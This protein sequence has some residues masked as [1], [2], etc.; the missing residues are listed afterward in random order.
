MSRPVEILT[1]P[2]KGLLYDGR[3]PDGLVEYHPMTAKEEKYLAGGFKDGNAIIDAII[4]SCVP[5]LTVPVDDLLI[6]DKFFMMLVI[7]ASSYGSSYGMEIKCPNCDKK[8]RHEIDL[9]FSEGSDEDAAFSIKVLDDGAKEPF[10]VTLP[11][12]KD[13]VQFR[14]LRGSDEKSIAKQIDREMQHRN[15]KEGNPA[16]I[17][18]LARHIVSVNGEEL[19]PKQAREYIE[20]LIGLDSAVLRQEID[21]VDV[22]VDTTFSTDCLYC[23]EEFEGVLAMG[24]EFFRPKY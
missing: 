7:R 14:L 21:N 17:Y 8:F 23:N 1:L 18:R 16:Y 15:K 13:T 5:S 24:P 4:R 22:G 3:V 12:C 11:K 20:E 10:E 19:D 9:G 6:G 2:S